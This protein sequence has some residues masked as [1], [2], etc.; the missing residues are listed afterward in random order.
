[1][2]QWIN[3]RSTWVGI[4][5]AVVGIVGVLSSNGVVDPMWATIAAWAVSVFGFSVK[6]KRG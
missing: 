1:M 6:D 4:G 2:K 3:Q 5:S